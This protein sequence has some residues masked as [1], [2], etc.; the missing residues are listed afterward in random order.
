MPR[1][2]VIKIGDEQIKLSEREILF[3]EHYLA[4]S[5]RN[6]TQAAISAGYSKKTARQQGAR[7]LTNVNVKKYIDFKTKPILEKLGVTQERII[8][9]FA[10]IGFSNVTHFLNDDYSMKTVDQLDPR[11][12]GAISQIKVKIEQSENGGEDKTIEFKVWDKVKALTE[13]AELAGLKRSEQDQPTQV[14]QNNYYG[15]INNHIKNQ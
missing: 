14:V 12:T 8:S 4:D 3:S 7:L 10:S 2:Q 5:N 11:A 1:Q 13:L 15:N 6:A 9:E